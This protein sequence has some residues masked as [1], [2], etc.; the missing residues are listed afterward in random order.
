[1]GGIACEH[2]SRHPHG[3]TPDVLAISVA[4]PVGVLIHEVALDIPVQLQPL[5]LC[6]GGPQLGLVPQATQRALEVV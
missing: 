1:M 3:D 5:D 4:L 6:L 2:S